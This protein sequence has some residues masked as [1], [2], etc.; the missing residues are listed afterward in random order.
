[1]IAR[2]EWRKWRSKSERVTE[3]KGEREGAHRP[4]KGRQRGLRRRRENCSGGLLAFALEVR[5]KDV[6]AGSGERE[7]GEGGV[8][9]SWSGIYNIDWLY[10][11]WLY[12]I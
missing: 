1:M 2:M 6:L 10:C 5:E 12:C 3:G 4:G 9:R 11:L 7:W 8:S